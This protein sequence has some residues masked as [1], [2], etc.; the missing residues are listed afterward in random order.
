M[1]SAVIYVRSSTN[2]RA[3]INRQIENCRKFSQ[4]NRMVVLKTY[5]DTD[6]SF[7]QQESLTED[8]KARKF[9]NVITYSLDRLSRNS[10][11]VTILLKTFEENNV[12]IF[13]STE[14]IRVPLSS[15]QI[16]ILESMANCES[17]IREERE[18]INSSVQPSL[19]A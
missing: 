4:D 11:D 12:K 2:N 1:N 19:P 13:F 10:Q 17:R 9:R 6:T 5:I 15:F 8:C 3:C 7:V 14:N 16:G 18:L